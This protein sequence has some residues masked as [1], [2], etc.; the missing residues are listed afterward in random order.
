MKGTHIHSAA[1]RP[2]SGR[3]VDTQEQTGVQ[4]SPAREK[5]FLFSRHNGQSLNGHRSSAVGLGEIR[6]VVLELK[7]VQEPKKK[8]RSSAVHDK[9]GDIET[10]L[11]GVG[12]VPFN[13]P[14]TLLLLVCIWK[15]RVNTD[16]FWNHKTFY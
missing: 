2:G 11:H 4:I 14:V 10:T 16:R 9:S 5:P 15:V 8:V 7:E 12:Y 13:I 6:V 3:R 1:R